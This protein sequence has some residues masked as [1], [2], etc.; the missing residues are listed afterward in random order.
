MDIYDLS[1][2]SRMFC[3]LS[4]HI[5]TWWESSDV[6]LDQCWVVRPQLFFSCHLRPRGARLPRRANYLYCP[7]DIQVQLVFYSTLEP[8]VLPWGGAYGSCGRAEAVRALIHARSVC[9]P[10]RRCA[11]ARAVDAP[12]PPRQ[13]YSDHPIPAPPA[14]ESQVST[15]AGRFSRRVRQPEAGREATCTRSKQRLRDQ[16]MAVAVWAGQ[17]ASGGP[18]G[19]PGLRLRSGT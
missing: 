12:V 10:R 11:G 16:P 17:T 6:S 5:C 9:G 3:S 1:L 2:F 14:S 18:V 4:L 7:D 8:M 19:G 15:W 13:L